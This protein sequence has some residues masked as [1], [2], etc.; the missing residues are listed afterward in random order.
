M[1]EEVL[2]RLRLDPGQR[3]LGQL[4]Q[5][6]E[7]AYQEIRRLREELD[8]LRTMRSQV[9]DRS[10]NSDKEVPKSALRPGTLIGI[11]DVA[12]LVSVSRPTIY[13]WVQNGDFPQPVRVGSNAVRWKAEDVEQWRNSL[14]VSRV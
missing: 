1:G 4:L 11:K 5:D 7:A 14:E 6:R 10:K 2:D 3:T 12:W 9:A 13:R 8:R